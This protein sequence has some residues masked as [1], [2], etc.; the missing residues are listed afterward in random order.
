MTYTPKRG[1]IA[2]IAFA[3]VVAAVKIAGAQ[4]VAPTCVPPACNPS[5]IQNIPLTGTAQSASFNVTGDGKVGNRL[6]GGQVEAG[7]K[8]IAGGDAPN[9]TSASDVLLYGNVAGG[10]AGSALMVLRAAGTERLRIGVEGN[11]TLNGDLDVQGG[12]IWNTAGELTIAANQVNLDS[13]NGT[14]QLAAGDSLNVPGSVAVGGTLNAS[15]YSG[16][17]SGLTNLNASNITSGTLAAARLPSNVALRDAVNNFTTTNTFAGNVG[18]GTTSP[19]YQLH[20]LYGAATG[21]IG[22]ASQ[23]VLQSETSHG[24]QLTACDACGQYIDF[25]TTG[26]SAAG[27]IRFNDTVANG[28]AIGTGGSLS[29]FTIQSDGRIGIG[30]AAPAASAKAQINAP[31]ST[32]GLRIVSAAD[33]SPINVRNSANSADIFRVDQTGSLAVGSVPWARLTGFPAACPAGQYASAVDGTLTCSAPAFAEADTLQTVTNRGN[34][35]TQVIGVGGASPVVDR[36]INVQGTAY[37]VYGVATD[38]GSTGMYGQ[39]AAN[40]MYGQGAAIGTTG[41]GTGSSST[42]VYGVG[43]VSGYGVVGNAGYA[44]IYGDGASYGGYFTGTTVGIYAFGTTAVEANGAV[45]VSGNTTLGDATTD[46]TAINGK[47]VLGGIGADP[48]GANGMTFYNTATNKFRCYENGA[49]KDCDTPGVGG[50]GTT[51]TVPK[52]TASTTLGDSLLTDDG[53]TVTAGGNAIVTGTMRVNGAA[54]LGGVG[55]NVLAAGGGSIGTRSE[56]DGYGVFGTTPGGAGTVGVRGTS[57]GGYGLF[58]DGDIGMYG[59]GA[60]YG[61]YFVGNGGIGTAVNAVGSLVVSENSTLGNTTTDQASINGK[62]VLG[63]I[64]S[65]PTGANGMMYYNTAGKFRCYELGA[66]KDCITAVATLQSAYDNGNSVETAAT[67]VLVQET[68][69]GALSHSLLSVTGNPATAGTYTGSLVTVT[70]NAVDA[71]AFSGQGIRVVVYPT[72]VLSAASAGAP[73]LIEDDAGADLFYVME[74]GSIQARNSMDIQCNGCGGYGFDHTGTGTIGSGARILASSTGVITNGVDVSDAEIVNAVNIGANAIQGSTGSVID[75]GINFRADS[76]TGMINVAN[77]TGG[78][79]SYGAGATLNIGVANASTIAMGNAASD[80]VDIAGTI[81]VGSVNATGDDYVYFDDLGTEYLRWVDAST[82]FNFSDDVEIGGGLQFTTDS[83]SITFQAADATNNPMIQMFASGTS[84]GDRMVIAHSPTYTNYGLQ[85][86]D[87]TDKFHFLSS[88]TAVLT[89]D[90]GNSRVGIGDSTPSYQ[91]ELSTNSAAKPTSTAWT[92][93][94]DRRLKENIKP[95][96]DGLDVLNRINP[97]SYTLNGK[98]GLPRG[99]AGISIIAQDVKDFLP[100]A[101]KTY[102]QRLNP[103]DAVDTELYNFDGSP[104]TFV[105]INAVKELN[106]KVD[107]LESRI[108]ELETAIQALKN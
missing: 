75:L 13:T 17:A 99:E 101:V 2:L 107:T 39:G 41:I 52:F 59:T 93:P 98:A 105:L 19:G 92:V 4:F 88:G 103:G 50:S 80:D 83:D 104:L 102:Q 90:L 42:G 71:N 15:G 40:G 61:G 22:G 69:G 31:A 89:V 44:G 51:N 60:T 95:F 87:G 57:T 79:D 11:G 82:K 5:V 106:V 56:G 81:H 54:S 67:P 45:T 64:G 47:F 65:D 91:L 55:L 23:L 84:N 1:V 78:L 100:Y 18:I 3:A 14:I 97:V 86:Q 94:S 12:N 49:W 9:F 6:I 74:S 37:G 7:G 48:A 25:G 85:Y 28:F 73:L 10:V 62:F 20:L 24:L 35:T 34:V 27:F 76:S 66:W 43:G 72:K 53:T 96:T 63:S 70:M 26:S 108:R 58:G 8:I 36:G 16:N 21:Q 29:A 33:W 32:E 38:A 46:Q 68:S 77:N 30:T